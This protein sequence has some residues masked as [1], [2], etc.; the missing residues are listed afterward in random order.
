M[1]HHLLRNTNRQEILPV[2]HHESQSHEIRDD[3]AGSGLGVDG[4]VVLEGC[5]EG[6]EGCEVG[7]WLGLAEFRDDKEERGRPFQVERRRR[8]VVGRMR[9]S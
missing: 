5:C 2:M 4:C 6:G 3:G 8:S 7:A 1:T 9:S